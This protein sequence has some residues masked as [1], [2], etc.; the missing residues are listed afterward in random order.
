[1]QA[2]YY[3]EHGTEAILLMAHYKE[4]AWLRKQHQ[5]GTGNE[6]GRLARK[7]NQGIREKA[8]RKSGRMT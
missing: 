6:T 8:T 7:L 2:S 1:M 5:E 3:L 4:A